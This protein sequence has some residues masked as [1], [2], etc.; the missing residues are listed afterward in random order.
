M[1][2]YRYNIW[3]P[4]E[5]CDV[6]E[7]NT[8]PP[9]QR[10]LEGQE[11]AQALVLIKQDMKTVSGGGAY[12]TSTINADQ[13]WY[14]YRIEPSGRSSWEVK[15]NPDGTQTLNPCGMETIPMPPPKSSPPPPE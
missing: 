8:D 2:S 13:Q 12:S 4:G 9:G 7:Y 5:E 1:I 10:N 15:F 14:W 3:S 11:K 6:T